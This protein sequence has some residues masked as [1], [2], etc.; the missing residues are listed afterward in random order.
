[1]E[2][3]AVKQNSRMK[4]ESSRIRQ[5]ISQSYLCMSSPFRGLVT[6]KKYL[7]KQVSRR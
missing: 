3:K 5:T 6:T 4:S 7:Q 2:G 1:M